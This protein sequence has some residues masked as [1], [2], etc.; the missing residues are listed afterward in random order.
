MQAMQACTN[1]WINGYDALITHSDVENRLPATLPVGSF[2]LGCFGISHR[3]PRFI[4][5]CWKVKTAVTCGAG[6]LAGIGNHDGRVKS[7]CRD[8]FEPESVS[9][10]MELTYEGHAKAPP[11]TEDDKKKLRKQRDQAKKEAREAG[12][13]CLRW[14]CA[15]AQSAVG[16][17]NESQE[18]RAG[19]EVR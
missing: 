7:S 9:S 10:L 16:G 12:A 13:A 6:A 11:L 17:G 14:Q 3:P 2:N 1:R 8:V 4:Q 19:E 5:V 18:S 15:P